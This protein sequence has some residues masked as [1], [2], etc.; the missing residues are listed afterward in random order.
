MEQTEIE[1]ISQYM[2]NSVNFYKNLKSFINIPNILN[3]ANYE[4]LPEDWFVVITD[5]RGSTEAIEAGLYKDVNVIGVSSI[6]AVKNACGDTDV[7]FI[8]G[9]DGATIFV[10]PEK[11]VAV[12]KTLTATK[13]K[14]LSDFKLDLRVSIIPVSEIYKYNSQI[15]IARMRLSTTAHVAMAKGSGILLAEELTKKSDA[16]KL[17][18]TNELENAHAGLECR[19]N[20]IKSIKGEILTLIIQSVHTNDSHVYREILNELVQICPDLSLVSHQGLIASWPPQYLL[21]ELKLKYNLSKAYLYYLFL[22][23]WIGFLSFVI[24]KTRNNPNSQASKYIDE[25]KKNTDFI[26]FDETLRMVIDVTQEQKNKIIEL[27]EVYKN[28]N[29]IYYGHHSSS[30]ALMTCYVQTNNDHLH[31]VDGNGGGYTLAAKKLKSQ[32]ALAR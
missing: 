28:N 8:F 2:F 20:P 10:P 7:P 4:K 24:N 16:Y 12:K 5:V 14:A 1:W 22:L 18:P 19:W 27:L 23:F 11:I 3:P 17:E 9:G 26:K 6:I 25:L 13:R 29:T 30:E 15:D 32:K 31:F 21:K